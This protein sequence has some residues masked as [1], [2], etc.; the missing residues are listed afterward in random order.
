[1]SPLSRPSWSLQ[2]EEFHCRGC[3]AQE[4]YQSRARGFFERY[5]LPIL[6]LQPVR[7]D[8]C[9]QRSYVPKTILVRER[10][11]SD[12]KQPESEPANG[13]NHDSRIA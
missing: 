11:V 8:H 1:M 4:A 12:R 9:Y 5:V 6:F 2:F 3:G 13:S 10:K 7:C